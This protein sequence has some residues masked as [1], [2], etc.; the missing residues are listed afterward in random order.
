MWDCIFRNFFS[1]FLLIYFDWFP[2]DIYFNMLNLD[3][4]VPNKAVYT[5]PIH[6]KLT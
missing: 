6:A 2:E 3:S 1:I 5:E 4:F